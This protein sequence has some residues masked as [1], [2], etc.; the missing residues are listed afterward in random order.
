MAL[1]PDF[2]DLLACPVC[3]APVVLEEGGDGLRCKRCDLIYPI[4][5]EIPQMLP[6]MARPA[7]ARSEPS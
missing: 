3:K 4:E 2:L 5:D 7:E 6:E 1:D